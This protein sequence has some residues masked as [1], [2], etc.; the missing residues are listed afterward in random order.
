MMHT[1]TSGPQSTHGLPTADNGKI[2][3]ETPRFS[4]CVLI[5]GKDP[6][7]SHFLG[8]FPLSCGQGRIL[9]SVAKVDLEL[10]IL[11][12]WQT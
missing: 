8:V 11:L 2:S 4:A 12:P 3:C 9:N 6:R 10:V 1:D 7:T 5:L